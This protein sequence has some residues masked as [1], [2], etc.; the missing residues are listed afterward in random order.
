MLSN[1]SVEHRSGAPRSIIAVRNDCMRDSIPA[2]PSGLFAGRA[3]PGVGCVRAADSRTSTA[4]HRGPKATLRI[5]EGLHMTPRPK[6]LDPHAGPLSFGPGGDRYVTKLRGDETGGVFS[7]TEITVA[8]GAGPPLHRH[9]REDEVFLV[10]EGVVSFRLENPAIEPSVGTVV[11]GVRNVA[12]TFRNGGIAPA[13]MM[14]WVTPPNVDE[15]FRRFGL[16]LP[17][18]TTPPP[19]NV[20]IERIMQLA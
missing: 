7:M 8:P 17:N 1:S 13:R 10:L 9:T 6:I 12:H 14:V 19:D 16:P 2:V 4:N 11:Y 15:F 3:G 18:S 20:I 5:R